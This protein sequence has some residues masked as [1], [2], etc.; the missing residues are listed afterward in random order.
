MSLTLLLLSLLITSLFSPCLSVWMISFEG[1]KRSSYWLALWKM[2]PAQPD[3]STAH[4]ERTSHLYHTS[5]SITPCLVQAGSEFGV[6]GLRRK[7]GRR[8]KRRRV[9]KVSSS[10]A[11]EG[12]VMSRMTKWVI[13]R[14]YLTWLNNAW[15]FLLGPF[16]RCEH[17]KNFPGICFYWLMTMNEIGTK[18]SLPYI[19]QDKVMETNISWEKKAVRQHLVVKLFQIAFSHL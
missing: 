15:K 8:R 16:E 17:W 6:E 14:L 7:T 1:E 3:P 12:E 4:C 11:E 19:N 18:S 2:Q 13:D 10:S 5:K 9:R